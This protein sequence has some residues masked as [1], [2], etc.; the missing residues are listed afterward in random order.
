MVDRNTTRGRRFKTTI[1]TW[2]AALLGLGWLAAGLQIDTSADLF[3]D[4]NSEE[5]D[6][7]QFSQDLFG[8]DESIVLSLSVSPSDPAQA[9]SAMGEISNALER[10]DGIRRVDS[11][12]TLPVILASPDSSLRLSPAAELTT[13]PG[14]VLQIA[15]RDRI[16]ARALISDDLHTIAATALLDSQRSDFDA[17]ASQS[18]AIAASFGAP[19]SGVP[20]F[21]TAANSRTVSDLLT[22]VPLAVLLIS[23][24]VA[25]AFRSIL[26]IAIALMPGLVGT[27]AISASASALGIPLNLITVTLPAIALALGAA[28]AMH[29]LAASARESS[30][31]DLDRATRPIV[32]SG[33]ST[34]VAF[35]SIATIRIE[36]VS[37]LGLLGA[38]GVAASAFSAVTL[39]PALIA[40]SSFSWSSRRFGTATSWS[41]SLLRSRS[42]S[43]VPIATWILVTIAFGS[44]L[45]LIDVRTDVTQ[46]F[47]KGTV[48]RDHYEEIKA[49]LSGISPVNIVIS[50]DSGKSV[51]S[52]EALASIDGLSAH[53][54]RLP[55]VGKSLSI[56]DP[57]RQLHGGFT[58]DPTQPLPTDGPLVSQYLLLLDSLEQ[59]DDLITSD[60]RHANIVLRVDDNGSGELQRVVSEAESW[61]KKF[62][63]P[64]F[65][66]RGTGIMYEFARAEDEITYGMIRGTAIALGVVWLICFAIF[67]SPYLAGITMVPNVVPLIVLGGFVGI[68]GFPLDAATVVVACLAIGIGVDDSFHLVCRYIDD[69]GAN[70]QERIGHALRSTIVPITLTTCIVSAGFLV[71][72]A[73]DFTLTRSLG[74]LTA[75]AMTLCLLTDMTLLPSLL[76]RSDSRRFSSD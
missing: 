53:L 38:I 37:Q 62:G 48:P 8:G 29:P 3:L 61:W 31:E 34:S 5:Y 39:V 11:L 73:S 59:L 13:D 58:G 24:L 54:G 50:S 20:V 49:S 69:E 12:H 63:T 32:Y 4:R 23:I 51:V 6:F 74:M 70:P 57:L 52:P 43:W 76:I 66:A 14:R 18:N 28:Y 19:I 75:M 71:L 35:L 30:P 68:S 15:S 45:G 33:I 17:I 72:A 10:I 65:S 36:A 55:A 46:W 64:G 41:V 2:S 44:C 16:Y 7:Y 60:H 67:R 21:R 56:G 47:S 40:A 26:A 22:F 25:V 42:A 9:I 27:L 1:L